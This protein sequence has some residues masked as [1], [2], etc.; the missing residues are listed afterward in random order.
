MSLVS[1]DA[2]EIPGKLEI[3]YRY[4]AGKCGSRFLTTL[5]DEK[6][7]LAARCPHCRTVFLPPRRVCDKC[8]RRLDQWV[9]VGPAGTISSFTVLHYWEPYLP[10]PPPLVMAQIK[11]DGADTALTHLLRE[12]PPEEVKIGMRVAPVFAAERK[13]RITD[14]AYFK[15]LTA[16]VKT[17]STKKA[18]AKTQKSPAAKTSQPKITRKKAKPAAPKTRAKKTAGGK[19][20]EKR[21]SPRKAPGKNKKRRGG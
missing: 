11:L 1:K 3:P 20:G 12:V 2:Y 17:T 7:I 4:F 13:A 14:I 8:Y 6:K 18:A 19:S 5:R 16:E 9:E 21:N 15:P 10:Y